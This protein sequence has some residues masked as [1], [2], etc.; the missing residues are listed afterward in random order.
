MKKKKKRNEMKKLK[1]SYGNKRKNIFAGLFGSEG[2]CGMGARALCDDDTG[3]YTQVFKQHKRE[4][5]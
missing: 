3:V 4:K 2:Y 5:K 1:V